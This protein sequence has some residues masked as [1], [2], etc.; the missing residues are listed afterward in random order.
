MDIKKILVELSNTD[1]PSGYEEAVL[2]KIEKLIA[3]YV[4][5]TWRNSMSTLIAEKKGN[6]KGKLGV[7]AHADEVGFVISK[8]EEDGFAR[9]EV[10]G[11]IDPKVSMAQR[12]KIY[13]RDGATSGVIGFLAPHL[14]KEEDR[15]SMPHPDNIFVDIS[16]SEKRVRVGDVSVPDVEA[17]EINS[18]ISG[19]ALDNR[20]G[21]ASL[22]WAAKMLQ[23]IRNEWD[24]YFIF[25]SEEEIAGPGART[26]AYELNLD[27]AIVVDVT[28]ANEKVP[29]YPLIK[30]GEGPVLTIGPMVDKSFKDKISEICSRNGLKTQI[31][32]APIHSGTDADEVQIARIGIST[33]VVS[34]PLLFMHSPVET[35]D[36]KDVEETARLIAVVA[37]EME[38]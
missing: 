2:Q 11:G 17:C 33:T 10:T 8:I 26:I 1:G 28:H 20:S 38:V 30:L 36:P 23:K 34:I 19:K 7:F 25:S 12:V 32:P 22:I 5:R 18:K 9:I 29:G 15:K 24:L 21:C 35:V 31:E 4:D 13:T 16:C 37:A 14:Q 3:P 6:G 27:K